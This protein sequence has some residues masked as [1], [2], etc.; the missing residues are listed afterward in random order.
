MRGPVTTPD[1]EFFLDD[2]DPATAPPRVPLPL[3]A[4]AMAA[5]ARA[6]WIYRRRGW[7][8][9]HEHLQR[10]A[11][12][13]GTGAYTALP[14]ATAIRLARREIFY[15][16]LVA[17]VLTPDG[18]CLPRSFALATYLT[19]LGLPAQAT[20]ARARTSAV[21]RNTFHSWTEL[22]GAVLNDNP[23]VQLGYTVL[24]R[25]PARNSAST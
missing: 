3:R 6:L 19:A 22:H 18:L 16:Q 11:P 17:R 5:T 8:V 4:H 12:G 14:A 24:Q 2:L 20:V 1:W 10:L 7:G 13:P 21:P 9:A 15:C 23:D 25:V